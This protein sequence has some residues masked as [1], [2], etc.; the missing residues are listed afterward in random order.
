MQRVPQ[1]VDTNQLA[2]PWVS[3]LSLGSSPYSTIGTLKLRS[4]HND[5]QPPLPELYLDSREYL[6][7]QR[8]SQ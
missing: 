3:V 2:I 5:P 7:Q 1:C 4:A 6:Y 8:N